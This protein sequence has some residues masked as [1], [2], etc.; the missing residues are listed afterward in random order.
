MR[1]SEMNFFTFPNFGHSRSYIMELTSPSAPIIG[2]DF[3][4][5]VSALMGLSIDTSDIESSAGMI[6]GIRNI[7][8]TIPLEIRSL[9]QFVPVV[10]IYESKLSALMNRL[11]DAFGSVVEISRDGSFVHVHHE[12]YDIDKLW[13]SASKLNFEQTVLR[14][15]SQRFRDR[16][17]AHFLHMIDDRCPVVCETDV[18]I[19]RCKV[20]HRQSGPLSE[21]IE[22]FFSFLKVELFTDSEGNVSLFDRFLRITWSPMARQMVTKYPG[23]PPKDMCV[24]ESKILENFSTDP[25][26][27]ILSNSFD[28]AAQSARKLNA[29]LEEVRKRI[30]CDL[31]NKVTHTPPPPNK[32]MIDELGF[33]PNLV[34][35]TC[36]WLVT[37]GL[38]S[39]TEIPSVVAL[40]VLMRRPEFS[41]TDALNGRNLAIF[42]QDA[43]YL[44]LHI[45][46]IASKDSDRA[47]TLRDQIAV[48]R[49]C[50]VKSV[51]FFTKRMMSR[52][53]ARIEASWS[54]SFKLGLVTDEQETL[55]DDCIEQCLFEIANCS[56]EWN[57]GVQMSK[58]VANLWT[59]TIADML[60][61]YMNSVAQN[62]AAVAMTA[63]GPSALWGF[64]SRFMGSIEML[65]NLS[66]FNSYRA[67]KK[68]QLA[69][70]GTI[71]DINKSHEPIPDDEHLFGLA[72]SGLENLLQCNPLLKTQSRAALNSL[73]GKLII[74]MNTS[75][76]KDSEQ[77]G[78][79]SYAALFG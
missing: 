13:T 1:F 5:A 74:H 9:R 78:N 6:A 31:V 49:A 41:D 21:C 44:C 27:A 70:S 67:A 14:E 29:T 69:L 2:Q 48:I 4:D 57:M 28:E 66:C 33:Y 23:G 25:P 43:S 30:L 79:R 35:E 46:L 3:L 45:A 22:S 37:D 65:G 12:L 54:K 38:H 15:L 61:K 40:F 32:D 52:F 53:K 19:W 73:L 24:L 39:T 18:S 50:V 72:P 71:N 68:I 64:W 36:M 60:L 20:G 76:F 59:V 7:Y 75:S 77:T 11:S 63:P 26:S 34:S 8:D 47:V 10:A 56:R 16:V 42:F 62:T 55:A 51:E 17:L 58:Q